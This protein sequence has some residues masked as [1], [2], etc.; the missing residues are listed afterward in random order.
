[1]TNWNL[2]AITGPGP[3]AQRP[4]VG[5]DLGSR[6]S[7]G[8]LLAGRTVHTAV[9]PT[10]LFMQETADE[11]VDKLLAA[12]GVARE[13]LGGL[14]ATGYGR[15]ALRFDDLPF[16]VV[17]EITCHAMGAHT[18]CP[19][20]RTIVD[21][22]GQDS[23]AIQVDPDTGR[24]VDFVMNDK[25]AA[26]TGRFLEKAALLLGL[27]LRQLGEVA[28]RAVE[29]AAIS[30]QCVVFAES[31][32]VSLRARADRAGDQ[33]A[34]AD[35]AAGV[36]LA[37][38]RRVRNLLGRVGLQPKL[39]FTGG[40][41]NNP[42]MRRALESLME[43]RF[44]LVPFDLTFAGAL[45]AA[46]LARGLV[47]QAAPAPV[48]RARPAAEAV[49]GVQALVAAA[50]RDFAA[51]DDADE[52]V[53]YL[54]AYTPVELV[55]ASGARHA[56]LF[57][58]G[59]PAT[60][61]RG[62]LHTQ[63]VFCD[64]S[65]SCLGEVAEG[66]PLAEVLDKVY[67][68]HTCAS[69]KRVGEVM[70]EFVPTELLT[71]PK[72]RDQAASRRLFREELGAMREDL[73]ALTGRAIDDAA[74]RAQI[75]AYGRARGLLVDLSALRRRPHPPLTGHEYLE[76]VRGFYHL[77]PD[78][79]E[80]AYRPLLAQL[81]LQPEPAAPPPLRLMV[82]G[83]IMGEGDRRI[84]DIVE[85]ELGARVVVEDH[86]AGVRPF[87]QAPSAA[88]DPLQA[89]ADG[90]LDQAPCARMK[91][92]DEAIAFSGRLA[93]EYQVDAVL[94]V[95]LKFCACYG[96]SKGAFLDHYASLGIPVLDLSSDYSQSDHGQLKT[97]LEA[98]LEVLR[99]RA[100]ACPEGSVH[101]VR[102]TA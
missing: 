68:F 84:L 28:L 41:S 98:F 85:G 90:Y 67:A 32:M 81:A 89:L 43:A 10:G 17:T 77:P 63:S 38:A 19:G 26:G 82:S 62:E 14:V 55:A 12:A 33:R 83:S 70:G 57:R 65:K 15:I 80:V 42:G 87:L 18:V 30:S 2:D 64:F 59:D 93:R 16:E 91:P 34:A 102:A 44:E 72:L 4:L 37:S 73:E 100:T 97:R 46:V 78:A 58:A 69:M 86:C 3:A 96:V 50:Q 48:D 60:V 92:L 7:K 52:R 6:A 40:V 24:V 75:E 5:I 61:S 36:H 51:G 20:T 53:G 47:R 49:R 76:L 25:C 99:G 29:P 35:I 74:L 79:L 39:V 21:I 13:A 95:Y 56:R 94:F 1:M 11:L 88:G 101:H 31:E 22:G 27:E 45:G 66:G 23:K 8:V 9:V 71:L 54:C